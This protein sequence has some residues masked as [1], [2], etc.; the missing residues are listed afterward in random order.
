V[1]WIDTDAAG[2]HH[3]TTVVRFVE[4][5]EAALVRRYGLEG[6]FLVAPRVRWE[7]DHTGP[8]RFEQPVS[9]ELTVTRVGTSSMTFAFEVW[10]EAHEGRPRAR[11]AHGSY[12]TVHIDGGHDADGTGRARSTPW[13]AAWRAA[14]A[15]PPPAVTDPADGPD[16][17]PGG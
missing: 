10:G 17:R 11:A 16:A 12:V 6:Y 13:P 4:A 15:G 3:H 9:T 2:I 1:E 5:A 8:L 14:L 7:V